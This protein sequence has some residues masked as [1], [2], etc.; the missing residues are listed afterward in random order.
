MGFGQYFEVTDLGWYMAPDKIK[1]AIA[2]TNKTDSTLY[3]SRITSPEGVSF[4]PSGELFPLPPQQSMVLDY[5]CIRMQK[6]FP[7]DTLNLCSYGT[8]SKRDGN[9][10]LMYIN[11][12]DKK[13]IV[14]FLPKIESLKCRYGADLPCQRKFEESDFDNRTDTILFS[15]ELSGVRIRYTPEKNIILDGDFIFFNATDKPLYIEDVLDYDRQ[16]HIFLKGSMP[17][18]ETPIVRRF[19]GHDYIV[20]RVIK[21]RMSIDEC[22]YLLKNGLSLRAKFTFKK[23]D[24]TFE[25]YVHVELPAKN[26]IELNSSF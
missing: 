24:L 8:Q 19:F 1:G 22:Q 5:F 9:P 23:D 16:F 18:M 12:K 6:L 17:N 4:Y 3:I 11:I 20:I 26:I 2:L 7:Y 13:T 14:K 15:P 25:T 21:A 10:L